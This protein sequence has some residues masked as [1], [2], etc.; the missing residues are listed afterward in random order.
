MVQT[1]INTDKVNG[2]VTSI[3]AA[4]TYVKEQTNL[5]VSVFDNFIAKRDTDSGAKKAGEVARLLVVSTQE[6][7]K[8]A[9]ITSTCTPSSSHY[10]SDDD[11]EDDEHD[12]ESHI[13]DNL[14]TRLR[15]I[16]TLSDDIERTCSRGGSKD[17]FKACDSHYKEKA[18]IVSSCVAPVPVPKTA[19]TITFTSPANQTMGSAGLGLTASS[20]SGLGITFASSTPL[21]CTV[22]GTTLTLVSPGSCSVSAS[23][24]G[25]TVYLAATPVSY[26]FTIAAASGATAQTITFVPPADQTIGMPTPGLTATASSGLAVAFASV[27][28]SVC[29][30]NSTA[31]TLLASGVCTVSANQL[32][33]SS[34][35]AATPVSGT[36]TVFAPAMK[37]TQTITFALPANQTMGVATPALSASSSSGLAVTL[38]SSTP[39]VCTVS[40]TAL[41]LV[42]AGACTVTANQPGSTNYE[43]ATTAART[44]TV[45]A[46]ATAEVSATNGK[47]VY[48][49]AFNGASCASCHSTFPALNVSKV[50]KGANSASTILNAINGNTGGMGVLR[51]VY[52]TQQLNDMAAYLATPGI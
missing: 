9:A 40:G 46:A 39:S 20:D 50:L 33:N 48:N 13:D 42:A 23:Q 1:K 8:A 49:T 45:A 36:F 51:N 14:L 35:T 11:H 17:G 27:T 18:R 44:F 37:A 31:L 10:E 16:R 28:P 21:V 38:A 24:L 47:V 25:N 4:E 43:A 22:N 2:T 26:T 29:T 15:E 6:S 5:T 12:K 3:E 52:T 19:Q 34:F 7:K 30:V 41:S 32:G